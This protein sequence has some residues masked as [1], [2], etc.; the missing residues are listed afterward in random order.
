MSIA[1]L[2]REEENERKDVANRWIQYIRSTLEQHRGY[3][4]VKSSPIEFVNNPLLAAFE[5]EYEY[6]AGPSPLRCL[7]LC[8]DV[9]RDHKSFDMK[10]AT[11]VCS[12]LEA[13]TVDH[14]ICVANSYNRQCEAKMMT[15]AGKK[16]LE[17]LRHDEFDF[18]FF[19]HESAQRHS[20]TLQTRAQLLVQFKYK[21]SDLTHLPTI[22]YHEDPVVRLL[23]GVKDQFIVCQV[24]S[25]TRGVVPYVRR[26]VG[27]EEDDRLVRKNATEALRM[28]M[29]ASQRLASGNSMKDED[30]GEEASDEDEGGAEEE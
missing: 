11:A 7:V 12:E 26:I 21:E 18:D 1:S 5:Y 10:L 13:P 23:G 28:G 19:A 22:D 29:Q 14:I 16:R 27:L 3:R 25:D 6:D 17:C 15:M 2:L 30:G 20:P 24:K 4:F 8:F 9:F